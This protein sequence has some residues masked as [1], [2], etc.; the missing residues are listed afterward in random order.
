MP[1]VGVGN[2]AKVEIDALPGEEFQG[3]VSRMADAEDPETRTMRVE[4]DL[5]NSDGTLREGMY[6]SV[7][8]RL[9]QGKKVFTVPSSCL[10]GNVNQGRGNV[11]VVE[12]GMARSRAVTVGT[13]N[14]VATEI[15]KGLGDQDEVVSRHSGALADGTPVEVVPA[16]SGR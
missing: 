9:N 5:P 7:T 10:V 15:L 2:P 14:G 1:F 4:V 6:G 12:N 13:D 8:I 11:Y 3:K 16:A